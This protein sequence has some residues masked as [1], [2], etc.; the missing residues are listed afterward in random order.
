MRNPVRYLS[1]P[2]TVPSDRIMLGSEIQN[3]QEKKK[4]THL[5]SVL[6]VEPPWIASTSRYQFETLV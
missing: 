4:S 1:L 2:A 3:D 6:N 5:T